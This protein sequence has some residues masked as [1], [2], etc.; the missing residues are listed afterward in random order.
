TLEQQLANEVPTTNVMRQIAELL[1]AEWVVAEVLDDGAAVG[2]G[3]RLRNLVFRQRRKSLEQQRPDLIFPEQVD[4]FFMRQD[5]ICK[6]AQ[7]AHQQDRED[8]QPPDPQEAPTTG[9]GA[10]Q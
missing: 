6:Q 10:L 9:D 8:C 7:A 4:N 1:A 2:I 3:M 5:G